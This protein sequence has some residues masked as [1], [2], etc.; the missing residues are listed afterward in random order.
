MT[1]IIVQVEAFK[2]G[3]DPANALHSKFGLKT[4]EPVSSLEKYNHLQIDVV[5]LFV[6]FLVQTV[7]S[8]L[9]II[10]CPDEV[11][12]VQNLV[13]LTPNEGNQSCVN[14]NIGTPFIMYLE[15]RVI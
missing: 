1:A 12:F 9:K 6:L 3:Q 14:K 4:G 15:R 11:A 10:Y 13:S 7:S 8:G 5:S 2:S